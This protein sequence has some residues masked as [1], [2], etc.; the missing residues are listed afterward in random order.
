MRRHAAI[1]TTVL[2]LLAEAR[3]CIRRGQ[4]AEGLRLIEMAEEDLA[5]HLGVNIEIWR[6]LTG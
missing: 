6:S 2:A 4:T 5:R 1:L 3:K